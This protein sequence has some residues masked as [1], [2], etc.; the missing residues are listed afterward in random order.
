MSTV[1]QQLLARRSFYLLPCITRSFGERRPGI[2]TNAS[3]FCQEIETLSLLWASRLRTFWVQNENYPTFWETFYPGNA[4]S[5]TEPPPT[6]AS[7]LHAW[8]KTRR[9]WVDGKSKR[10]TSEEGQ[11]SAMTFS[12]MYL[13][14]A[15]VPF[16]W[17]FFSFKPWKNPK[18]W[19]ETGEGARKKRGWEAYGRQEWDSQG[20]GERE[21]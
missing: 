4:L 19:W 15:H 6:V 13:S 2:S 5:P 20:G 9:G 18:V 21:K 10:R 8:E 7:W 16:S 1:K 3:M 11:R 14:M 12:P 17:L